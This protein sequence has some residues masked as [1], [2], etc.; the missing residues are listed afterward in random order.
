M[1]E[2]GTTIGDNV[3]IQGQVRIG[4]NCTIED[5]CVLKWGAILTKEV[6]LESNVFFGVRSTCL[7]SD[8]DRVD[9]HGT[10]IGENAYIGGHS[11][12]FPNIVIEDNVIVGAM[13]LVN[14]HLTKDGETYFGQPARQKK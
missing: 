10:I 13:S 1:I 4:E 11:V 3:V 14:K 8:S 9:N 2:A 6:H 12:I 7:G 5:D